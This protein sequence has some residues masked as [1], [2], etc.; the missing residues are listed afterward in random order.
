MTPRLTARLLSA[1]CVFFLAAVPAPSQ[2]Q[3]PIHLKNEQLLLEARKQNG[4]AGSTRPWHVRAQ[5]ELFDEQGKR[6]D[7]GTFEEW[8]F[9][10]K[11]Y[12]S[13][14]ISDSIKQ[15]DV[16]TDAGLYRAGDPRWM[17]FQED[18]VVQLLLD[19][20]AIHL[21]DP[22]LNQL[23]DTVR[24]SAATKFRCVSLLRKPA[25]DDRAGS[26]LNADLEQL[27]SNCFDGESPI[28]RV[29]AGGGGRSV[30]LL[31]GIG[32]FHEQYVATQIRTLNH[33][34]PIM[35][36]KVLGVDTPSAATPRPTPPEGA[37]LLTGPV[38]LP[39]GRMRTIAGTREA[40]EIIGQKLT[41][42]SK[43]DIEAVLT[44]G[45]DGKVSDV[46][47]VHSEPPI[48]PQIIKAGRKL[49]FEPF[50]ILGDPVDVLLDYRMSMEQKTE[51]VTGSTV[52]RSH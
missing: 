38:E 49:E 48:A 28:L 7:G 32:R 29:S 3:K 13:V 10:P 5:F 4:L 11:S 21:Y 27:P 22:K 41:R 19:P 23:V 45:K 26:N 18:E 25:P 39:S 33:G 42:D 14:Y 44:V 9:A 1:T 16:A 12:K 37:T 8:W 50:T 51:I 40:N 31:D 30:V 52:F 46:K 20:L 6:K 24:A 47:V 36:V 35:T 43:I 2:D 34:K 15:T 17:T